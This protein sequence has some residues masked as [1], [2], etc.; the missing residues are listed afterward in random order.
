MP[1]STVRKILT[2]S[3]IFDETAMVRERNEQK[4]SENDAY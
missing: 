2:T 1:N 4:A 3:P